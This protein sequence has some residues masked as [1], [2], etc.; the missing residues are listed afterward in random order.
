[1]IEILGIKVLLLGPCISIRPIIVW[2]QGCKID[3]K[4]HPKP[5]NGYR[6]SLVCF[7]FH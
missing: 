6:V 1:M 5:C 3:L 2:F 7:L 4:A